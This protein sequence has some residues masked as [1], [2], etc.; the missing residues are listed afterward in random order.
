VPVGLNP[1][2]VDPILNPPPSFLSPAPDGVDVAAAWAVADGSGIRFADVERSWLLT[3]EDLFPAGGVPLP[4]HGVNNAGL[5][6]SAHHGAAVLGIVAARDNPIGTVGMAPGASVFISSHRNGNNDEFHVASA[7][8]AAVNGPLKPGDVVLLEVQRDV[9]NG[10]PPAKWVAT[11]FDNADFTAIRLASALGLIVVEAAGTSQVGSD[12]AFDLGTLAQFNP[13]SGMFQGDSGAIMVAGALK[14]V[15]H[16]RHPSSNVGARVNSY[17]WGQDVTTV[18]GGTAAG[19]EI[20]RDGS[21]VALSTP[22]TERYTKEFGGSSAAAAIVAGAAILVQDIYKRGGPGRPPGGRLSPRRM[23]DLLSDAATC[24]EQALPTAAN[25]GRMPDL[26]KLVAALNAVPDLYLRDDV[27]DDGSVPSVGAVS[28]S[29]DIA[30][31]KTLVT[32]AAAFAAGGSEVERGHDNFVYVRVSNRNA[33]AAAGADVRVYWGEV[34]TLMP[35]STWKP[36]NP[37]NP[38]L[39]AGAVPPA[40]AVLNV[41]ASSPPLAAPTI[42]WLQANLPPTGHYCFVAKVNHPLDP[43]PDLV[44]LTWD[45]FIAYIRNNNNVTWRNFQ[46]VPLGGG[47]PVPIPFIVAG[48]FDQKRVFDLQI[49][50]RRPR[51]VRVVWELPLSLFAQL[52][53]AD[54]AHVE[55]DEK[56]RRARVHLQPRPKLVLAN[57]ALNKSAR[58]RCRFL[59]TGT[60]SLSDALC[61]LSIGQLY[62]RT[63][64]GRVTFRLRRR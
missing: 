15:P 55:I 28:V 45:Q 41:P 29:P 30:V 51:D 49:L 17:A 58:H 46:V 37:P 34:A 35:P 33:V 3:H 47:P 25:I 44:T 13:A 54:F 26:G 31:S 60:P 39:P 1:L 52:P 56:Q 8:L 22:E 9:N 23:R 16:A 11:E 24:T 7:I 63:E 10:V 20:K 27:G 36:L 61:T 38:P 48:A 14:T 18:S 12:P 62:E 32:A 50:Q 57:V 4:L 19:G 59:F 43:E 40:D 64:V 6:L 5:A 42:T 2:I 53:K 21:A